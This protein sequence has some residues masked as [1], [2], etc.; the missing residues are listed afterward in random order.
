MKDLYGYIID[1]EK[2]YL[3]PESGKESLKWR[4]VYFFFRGLR[5]I[6]YQ[7]SRQTAQAGL[8][9][10]T[11]NKV[12]KILSGVIQRHGFIKS[13]Q[14]LKVIELAV[15]CRFDQ[16]GTWKVFEEQLL[17]NSEYESIR[18]IMEVLD[19]VKDSPPFQNANFFSRM[20]EKLVDMRTL[21]SSRDI[22]DVVNLY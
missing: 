4:H 15:L 17:Y 22:I 5:H 14:I 18:D 21:L 2:N 13:Y 1:N 7:S 20:I 8:D 12:F 9:Q 11:E 3:S 19:T 10:A 6:Q 16:P